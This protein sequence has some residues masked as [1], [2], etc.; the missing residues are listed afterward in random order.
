MVSIY[1]PRKRVPDWLVQVN[2]TGDGFKSGEMYHHGFGFIVKVKKDFIVLGL[3]GSLI[4]I[5]GMQQAKVKLAPFTGG[6]VYYTT[7]VKYFYENIM[8][9][10]AGK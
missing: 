10:K 5:V 9:S 6:G 3:S 4:K 2:P 7:S 1:W 8:M